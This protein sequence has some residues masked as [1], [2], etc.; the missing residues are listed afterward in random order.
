MSSRRHQT[1]LQSPQEDPKASGRLATLRFAVP[2]QGRQTQVG[3]TQSASA[4]GVQRCSRPHANGEGDQ[5]QAQV[6]QRQVAPRVGVE[7][8]SLILIQD[9]RPGSRA[10]RDCPPC[11]GRHEAR[12]HP[13][14]DRPIASGPS[15]THPRH[16][17]YIPVPLRT[18]NSG[19]RRVTN[20]RRPTARTQPRL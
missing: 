16:A 18:T 17:H 9:P 11:R 3:Q 12:P 15:V 20:T 19:R 14:R 4:G 2:G 10:I 5:V 7:P 8:T 13:V 1:S 6:D